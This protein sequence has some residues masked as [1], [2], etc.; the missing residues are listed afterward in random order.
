[1]RLNAVPRLSKHFDGG[2]DFRFVG[3]AHTR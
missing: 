2:F 3:D 1:L